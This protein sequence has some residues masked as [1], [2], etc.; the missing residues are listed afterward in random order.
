MM[1]MR[2]KLSMK[3]LTMRVSL[4]TYLYKS[5]QHSHFLL[6]SSSLPR[7]LRTITN[8]KLQLATDY[9]YLGRL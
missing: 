6:F 9:D 2:V 7:H 3:D 5:E 8:H 1:V 4:N